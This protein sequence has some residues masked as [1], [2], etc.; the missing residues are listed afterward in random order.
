MKGER[1]ISCP[2]CGRSVRKRGP[3]ASCKPLHRADPLGGAMAGPISERELGLEE[4]WPAGE[5]EDHGAPE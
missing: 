5:L 1:T 3:C 2:Y 4:P